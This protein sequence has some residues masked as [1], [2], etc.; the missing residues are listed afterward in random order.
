MEKVKKGTQ[1]SKNYLAV[2]SGKIAD[3]NNKQRKKSEGS[4]LNKHKRKR[5]SEAQVA[6]QNA[7]NDWKKKKTK[8]INTGFFFIFTT[9]M[10]NEHRT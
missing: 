2:E 5:N 10:F 9:T 6:K 7:S 1:K 4:K 8:K 3:R